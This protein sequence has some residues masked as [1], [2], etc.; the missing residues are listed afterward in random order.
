MAV[1]LRVTES[2]RKF[3]IILSQAYMKC[4][5]QRYHHENYSE[6]LALKIA[7][8]EQSCRELSKVFK[9]TRF[10]RTCGIF[11]HRKGPTHG[12]TIMQQVRTTL[13]QLGGNCATP[14]PSGS[15]CL[16]WRGRDLVVTQRATRCGSSNNS[17]P[18]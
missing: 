2:N 6:S 10:V 11:T 13:C 17:E 1:L 16:V 12:Q 15:T 8:F 14:L 18:T 4:P 3:Y 7:C 5:L 9:S